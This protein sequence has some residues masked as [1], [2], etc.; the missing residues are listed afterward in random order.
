M[1]ST[2][3]FTDKGWFGIALFF[4]LLSF[5]Y[6]SLLLHRIRQ[7]RLLREDKS[8]IFGK[9]VYTLSEVK[10][11]EKELKKIRGCRG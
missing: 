4:F 6:L 2:I 1:I 9:L 3:G 10:Y 7:N 8:R 5:F 11:L